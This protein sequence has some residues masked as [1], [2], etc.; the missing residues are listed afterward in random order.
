MDGIYRGL[1]AEQQRLCALVIIGMNAQGEKHFVAMEDGVRDSTLSW[2]EVLS[3]LQARGLQGPVLAIGDWA[4]GF[5][6]AV[7][8]VYPTTQSQRGWCHK[9]RNVLNTIPTSRQPKAKQ[10]TDDLPCSDACDGGI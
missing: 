2:R 6:A 10:P 7:E 8:E 3:K 9:P 1:R 4:M 5:W